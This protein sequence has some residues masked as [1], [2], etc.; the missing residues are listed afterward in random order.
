MPRFSTPK[1][2]LPRDRWSRPLITPPADGPFNPGEPVPYTRTTTFAGTLDDTTMLTKWKMRNVAIGVARSKA[3]QMGALAAD[4]NDK[5]GK[6]TLDEIADNAISAASGGDA[7]TTGTALHSF[8]ERIERGEDL[9][10]VPEEYLPDLAAYRTILAD[11]GITTVAVEGF[12]VFDPLQIGGTYDRILRLPAGL[13]APDGQDLGA[14]GLDV[15]GDVKTGG[16]DFAMG[17]I[18]IQLGTY[19][20][21]L[22]YDHRDGSRRPLGQHNLLPGVE[23]RPVSRD[24]GIVIHLPAG[25]GQASLH[26][27]ELKTPFL[28]LQ[29]AHEVREYRK[30]ARDLSSRFAAV[31]VNP[32]EP[33]S[34]AERLRSAETLQ[35]LNRVYTENA[36]DW[37][38]GLTA[39]AKSIKKER[40]W[41]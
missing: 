5:S 33:L 13:K 4:P 14:L 38:P 40:G 26:W 35:D 9:G 17:K 37:T 1:S 11:N 27:V 18:A 20:N 34:L 23:S 15:I 24:W 25:A 21:S 19:A 29:L 16:I 32:E 31:S 36:R 12:C 22:D 28:A 41:G 7:A 39:L 8:T 6:R 2:E 3:L 30:R 10:F